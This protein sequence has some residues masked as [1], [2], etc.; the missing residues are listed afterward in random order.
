MRKTCMVALA[1]AFALALPVRAQEEN[2][3]RA[4]AEKLLE[5][6]KVQ[7]SIEESFAVVKQMQ[8]AQLKSMGISG[9]AADKAQSMQKQI[10]DL[11]AKELSWDKLKDDYIGIYAGT[12]TEDEL[13][14]LID[15]YKSP[16]GQKFI[17]KNPEL[18][19]KTMAITQKQMADIM[20]KIQQITMEGMMDEVEAPSGVPSGTPAEAPKAE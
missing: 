15:F 13:K 10:M 8:E 3:R 4:S 12:F 11:L 17:S 9:E 14:G 2:A 5:L 20:P 18:M 6:M 19:K 7:A 16:V 1:A